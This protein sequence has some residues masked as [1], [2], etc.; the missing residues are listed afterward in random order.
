MTVGVVWKCLVYESV[1]RENCRG[2]MVVRRDLVNE[3]VRG[4][5]SREVSSGVWSLSWKL[6]ERVDV[7]QTRRNVR[8]AL[9]SLLLVSCFLFL[10]SALLSWFLMLVSLKHASRGG[11]RGR[12]GVR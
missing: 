8:L 11:D 12:C 6:G 3:Q 4:T 7:R 10:V 2:E 1:G 9:N 5:A